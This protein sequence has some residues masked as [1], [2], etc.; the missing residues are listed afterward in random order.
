MDLIHRIRSCSDLTPVDQQFAHAI[1]TL[2]ED[3]CD[4]TIE[5]LAAETHVSPA[6][7]SRFCKRIGLKGFRELKVELAR[8]HMARRDEPPADTNYPFSKGDSPRTI[9]GGMRAL[10]DLALQDALESLDY[11]ELMKV[12]QLINRASAVDIYT[13]SHNRAAAELFQYRMEA[14]GRMVLVPALGE[15]QRIFAAASRPDHVALI[16]SYSGRATFIPTVLTALH[17]RGTPIVLLG[18]AEAAELHPDIRHHLNISDLEHPQLRIS[19]FA[20]HAALEFMLDVLYGC[21]FTLDYDANTAF[22]SDNAGLIDDRV[23]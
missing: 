6:S 10:Y 1:L 20:S 18:T 2:P 21:V 19:Q 4:R 16:I 17:R 11:G 3:G 8:Y 23:F 9:A 13:H 5:E 22:I 14:I 7:I 12:A 15:E